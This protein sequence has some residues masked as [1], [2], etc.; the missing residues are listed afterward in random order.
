MIF[1]ASAFVLNYSS[2]NPGNDTENV[3]AQQPTE[4]RETAA[5]IPSDA[6]IKQ[7]KKLFLDGDKLYNRKKYDEAIRAYTEAIE[8]NP[9]DYSFFNNRG[10]T[11]HAKGEFENA[12]ADYTKAVEINPYHFSSYNNRGAAYEDIGIIEQAIA[13]Y[14][15]ALELEPDNKIAQANLKKVLGKQQ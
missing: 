14:R 3:K 5:N 4:V 11:F 1:L 15:K 10:V 9:N 6:A 8:L 7:S 12:I 13:D 2:N